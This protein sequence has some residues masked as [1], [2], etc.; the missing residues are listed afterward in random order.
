MAVRFGLKAQLSTF[1]CFVTLFS[2]G[3]L[4]VATY[5]SNRKVVLELLQR[6]MQTVT[7][8]KGTQ[9]TQ[10]MG[11]LAG[12]VIL[13]A[14]RGFIQNLL[15]NY[16]Q[17]GYVPEGSS[18]LHQAEMFLEST[19]DIL[20]ATL[21]TMG[22]YE[23]TTVNNTALGNLTLP[24]EA[25][26]AQHHNSSQ[27]Y[28]LISESSPYIMGPYFI[29]EGYFISLTRIIAQNNAE[30][31][32]HQLIGQN[33]THGNSVGY[34][35]AILKA[36]HITQVLEQPSSSYQDV[37]L[38][39]LAMHQIALHDGTT[40]LSAI[41]ANELIGRY[42]LPSRVHN[43]NQTFNLTD[44]DKSALVYH[45]NGTIIN[46]KSP[47]GVTYS[48]GYAA[49]PIF[50]R[51]WA[52]IVT[53]SHNSLFHPLYRLRN[54]ILISVFSIGAG[55]S[56]VA[57]L[58][59]T[60]LVTPIL[61][62]QAATEQSFERMKRQ[63]RRW[64]TWILYLLGSKAAIVEYAFSDQDTN[65]LEEK[66]DAETN[67]VYNEK[68][69]FRLP[70]KIH[71][72]RRI[73]DELTELTERFNDMTDEL[74]KR[75]AILESRVAIRTKEIEGAR[76]VAESANEAKSLFMANITHELRTPLNGI[77]G[78]T[79]VCE[80]EE[81]PAKLKEALKV[82]F[83]S[84]ELL[85]HLL[86]DL[87][88]FS[89]NQVG[90]L[91]L[92]EK[93]FMLC[94]ALAQ[95]DAIF[96]TQ[97]KRAGID[98]HIVCITPSIEKLVFIGDINRILQIVINLVSNSLK[99]T[100]R[101]GSIDVTVSGEMSKQ[102]ELALEETPTETAAEGTT[103][104]RSLMSATSSEPN[105]D[106]SP[107]NRPG[108]LGHSKSISI[109]NTDSPAI[110]EE[111]VWVTWCVKD[112]G[113]GI[114]PALQQRIFE[115]FVQG[116]H[117]VAGAKGGA[118]LGLS[119]CRQLATLM[120]G[121]VELESQVGVGSIFTFRVP[122]RATRD[123][124]RYV[125]ADLSAVD[126]WPEYEVNTNYSSSSV[127]ART[128]PTENHNNK[129]PSVSGMSDTSS[130]LKPLT[131]IKSASGSPGHVGDTDD[132]VPA[133][134]SNPCSAVN[135]Q[136]LAT[137]CLNKPQALTPFDF[138]LERP[139]MSRNSSH[140]SDET[141]QSHRSNSNNIL[142]RPFSV[143][144]AEDNKVNQEV[145]IRMLKLEGIDKVSIANDGLE[146]VEHMRNPDNQFDV[147]FMDVQMPVMDGI[148]ATKVIRNE[149][150]FNG[151]IIAV[152]AFAD[153]S[154]V[155]NC[156]AVGMNHF[157]AKPLAR[158]HLHRLLSSLS[159]PEASNI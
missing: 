1:V 99:F 156:L 15:V 26:P 52:V 108:S 107:G 37:S 153:S 77:L 119:I 116:E 50:N 96:S 125:M 44:F 86:T 139:P 159:S 110:P 19:E 82:I 32:V 101:S 97:S 157:L 130:V 3:M 11:V 113:P 92:D 122:L 62:L 114:S 36:D 6:K 55:M 25:F 14:S 45:Q 61:K 78:M 91:D 67:S 100:P 70:K 109:S 145:L 98:L 65:S 81:D 84:G 127:G 41:P 9:I 34:V 43:F 133:S 151:L 140:R 10:A 106:R 150:H 83:K 104:G 131:S 124:S 102:L 141:K 66:S 147:V 158:P 111:I 31:N 142:G 35:T 132:I 22:L 68:Q 89:K 129:S 120:H 40:N 71:M 75:Y 80:G 38:V 135:L 123:G 2:L 8:L 105:G 85:L 138:K 144:V 115:P 48:V 95:L 74:R 148:E 137:N 58:V 56:I 7:L 54:M 146:A 12:D 93:E 103:E 143:L 47:K 46:Y 117:T 152:S 5:V 18:D 57:L 17:L 20:C 39:E 33:D 63:K 79:S 87:L 154:N 51:S 73:T 4:S 49:V 28:D 134:I 112:T 13:L 23:V 149:L 155:D 76:V 59:S 42:V 69:V 29:N 16:Y 126:D 64:Y 24:S 136:Q 118:G 30:F 88:I 90:R 72:H 128:P 21:Y 53:Q 94:E 27:L 121:S 60:W